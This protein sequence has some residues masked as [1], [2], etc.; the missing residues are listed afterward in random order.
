MKP[1]EE[2]PLTTCFLLHVTC[3][4]MTYKMENILA[5]NQVELYCR[6][7]LFLSPPNRL[8]FI[9]KKLFCFIISCMII[10]ILFQADDFS[11]KFQKQWHLGSF[12]SLRH[13]E[14]DWYHVKNINE[15]SSLRLFNFYPD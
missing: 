15:I 9:S 6:S 12:K 11:F 8:L 5:L 7:I 4:E 3:F 14:N 13:F 1:Q 10:L 2:D